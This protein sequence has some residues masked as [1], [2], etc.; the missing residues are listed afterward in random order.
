[1]G[2]DPNTNNMNTLPTDWCIEATEENFAELY[3]WWRA[4]AGESWKRFTIGFTLMSS[5]PDGSYYYGNCIESCIESHPNYQPIT[6]EQFRKI[7]KPMNTLPTKWCIG[8]TEENREE[9]DRWR[10]KVAT[11]HRNGELRAN[12]HTILSRHLIDGSHY[13][14]NTVQELRKEEGYKDYEEITI[15]QFR[16]I[17]NSTSTPN[18]MTKSIQIS[19]DLLNEYYEASTREQKA[20][21]SE[22]FKLD[23]TTT[24]EAIRGLHD[25][26]CGPWKKIIKRNHPDCFPADSKHFDFSK[27]GIVRGIVSDTVADSLGM[28]HDFIQIRNNLDNPET[29]YRSFYLSSKYDWKLIQDG[30]EADGTVWALIPTK[31]KS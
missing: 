27:P 28:T 8:V 4:N 18:T 10:L 2:A 3:D 5:H 7:T 20:Y 14:S 13:Y 6:I 21:L 26:A 17:T 30:E 23:G 25:L 12:E 1:M 16:E 29:H 15:E 9:L 11:S 31:K 22:H 19:R 24:I